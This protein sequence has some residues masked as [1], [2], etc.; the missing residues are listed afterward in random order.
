MKTQ[1]IFYEIKRILCL[2]LLAVLL[3]AVVEP[4]SVAAESTSIGSESSADLA[5][6]NSVNESLDQLI[7]W[8]DKLDTLNPYEADSSVSDWVSFCRGGLDEPMKRR[9]TGKP[10]IP[11]W[12]KPTGNRSF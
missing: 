6:D 12:K 2:L 11:M 5:V 9:L 4:V 8:F 7:S 1:N 3:T 10:F